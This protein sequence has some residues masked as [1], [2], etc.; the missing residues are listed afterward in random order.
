MQRREFLR[1][2]LLI[3]ATG[4]VPG[5]ALAASQLSGALP[6]LADSDLYD[7]LKWATEQ[8]KVDVLNFLTSL[9][10]NVNVKSERGSESPLFAAMSDKNLDMVKCLVSRGA[11]VNA[12][13]D[14]GE[15]PLHKAAYRYYNAIQSD[16]ELIRYLVS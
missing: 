2:G 15:T 12:K 6:P 7:L 16:F 11:N 1:S 10:V 3:G 4:A 8:K 9:G 5:V 13:S 14:N